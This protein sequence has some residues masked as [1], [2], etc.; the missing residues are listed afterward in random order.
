MAGEAVRRGLV[1][2]I[3][4]RQVARFLAQQS[5]A[6]TSANSGSLRRTNGKLPSTTKR[7]SSD[8]ARPTA[9]RHSW[10]AKA[11]T[12]GTWCLS[13]NFEVVT[14]TIV[15]PTLGPRRTEADFAAHLAAT[16][17]TAPEA[18]WSFVADQ[19]K[20]H[21]SAT[22][23]EGLAE[24]CAIQDDLGSK[25]ETGIPQSK[26]SRREFLQDPTQRIRFVYTPRHCSWLNQVELWFAIRAR[27]LRKRASFLAL[28][29]LRTRLLDFMRYFNEV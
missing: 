17:E 26:Q 27:R 19:L 22:R 7:L 4:P 5:C 8:S 25:G 20:T 15:T 1:E 21:L 10:P 23:V 28:N 11:R 16:V 29:E 2:R 14:G 13:A 6:R 18:T 3:S 9:T 12:H 24:C